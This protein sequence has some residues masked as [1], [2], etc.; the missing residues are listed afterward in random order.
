MGPQGGGRVPLGLQFKRFEGGD[1]LLPLSGHTDIGVT[2]R[3]V[4]LAFKE[5]RGKV[6]VDM[7]GGT[8][9]RVNLEAYILGTSSAFRLGAREQGSSS[10][11]PITLRRYPSHFLLLSPTS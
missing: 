7:L 10:A 5:D 9:S 11:R 1:R 8:R 6:I 3:Q 4:V 2:I